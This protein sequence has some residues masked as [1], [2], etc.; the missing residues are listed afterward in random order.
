MDL[1]KLSESEAARKA[2]AELEARIE[3]FWTELGVGEQ[4]KRTGGKFLL[5]RDADVDVSGAPFRVPVAGNYAQPLV[6]TPES[7]D[8]TVP[9]GLE[10]VRLHILG[11][12]TLPDGYPARGKPGE[13]IASYTVALAGG[14]TRQVP[15]RNGIEVAR[16]NV[17]HQAT[18]TNP[19]A[20]GAPRALM[21]TKDIVREHYQ[22]LLYSLPVNGR[23]QS[24][25]LRL[26]RGAD[27]LALFAITAERV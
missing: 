4:W 1:Q 17:I 9:L 2:W 10:C 15:L 3:K 23:V 16:S 27:P 26:K 20:A 22:V 5:W 8:L 6:V 18:R 24:I 12:V 7:P 14:K 19:I 13:A 21:F 11:H 25:T